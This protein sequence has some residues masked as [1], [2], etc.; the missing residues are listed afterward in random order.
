MSSTSVSINPSAVKNKRG[1]GTSSEVIS[2]D[3]GLL[4]LYQIQL[5]KSCLR[6]K[7]NGGSRVPWHFSKRISSYF[8]IP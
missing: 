6:A 5:H 2:A 1:G 4:T 8:S 3:E 7:A